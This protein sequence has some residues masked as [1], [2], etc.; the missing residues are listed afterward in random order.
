M[1]LK[2]IGVRTRLAGILDCNFIGKECN[3]ERTPSG[4]LMLDRTEPE[5]RDVNETSSI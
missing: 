1:G 5:K 3:L 2:K 4:E